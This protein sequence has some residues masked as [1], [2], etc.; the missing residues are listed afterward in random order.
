[1]RIMKLDKDKFMDINVLMLA[2]NNILGN[3]LRIKVLAEILRYLEPEGCICRS[4]TRRRIMNELKMSSDHY[5]VTLHR[6][7]QEDHIQLKGDLIYPHPKY[8]AIARSEGSLLIT[9]K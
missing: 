4:D 6:L 2:S 1:M 5:R 8:I 7:Q 9:T 3:N